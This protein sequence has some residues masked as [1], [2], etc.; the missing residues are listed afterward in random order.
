MTKRVQFTFELEDARMRRI[1]LTPDP[2]RFGQR[3]KG[4]LLGAACALQCET[5]L[6]GQ[7]TRNYRPASNGG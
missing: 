5:A 2:R 3:L 7:P 1:A 6:R 4:Q